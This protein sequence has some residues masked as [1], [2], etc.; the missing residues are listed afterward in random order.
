LGSY[1]FWGLRYGRARYEFSDS[2]FLNGS[3]RSGYVIYKPAEC[4]SGIARTGAGCAQRN[5]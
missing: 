4:V 5:A 2:R 1:R 3:T